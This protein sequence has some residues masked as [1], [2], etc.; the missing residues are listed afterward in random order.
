MSDATR[1]I[2]RTDTCEMVSKL[3]QM[4][5]AAKPFTMVKPGIS[6]T[7]AFLPMCSGASLM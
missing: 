6:A 4:I 5:P 1:K 3:F 2:L 7:A